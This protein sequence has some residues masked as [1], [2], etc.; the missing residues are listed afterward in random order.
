MS[1]YVRRGLGLRYVQREPRK[2]RIE[3]GNRSTRKKVRQPKL[4]LLMNY[5]AHFRV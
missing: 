5:H 1:V 3:L 4:T 2:R